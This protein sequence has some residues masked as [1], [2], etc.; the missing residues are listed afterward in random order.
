MKIDNKIP[1]VV[2]IQINDHEALVLNEKLYKKI[3]EKIKYYV[4]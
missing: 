4:D 3:R 2:G 1:L